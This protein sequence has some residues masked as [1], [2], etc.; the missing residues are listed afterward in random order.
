MIL[1]FAHSLAKLAYNLAKH[2]MLNGEVCDA[3]AT[4]DNMKESLKYQAE[5]AK[6]R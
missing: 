3:K 6:A 5:I 4:L 1:S 2:K